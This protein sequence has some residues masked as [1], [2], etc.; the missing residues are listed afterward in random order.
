MAAAAKFAQALERAGD[1]SSEEER[2]GDE[3]GKGGLDHHGA[4]AGIDIEK[5]HHL[6]SVRMKTGTV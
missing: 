4:G 1:L 2:N 6:D 5:G 3:G